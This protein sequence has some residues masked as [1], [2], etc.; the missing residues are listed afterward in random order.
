[1]PTKKLSKAELQEILEAELRRRENV[2]RAKIGVPRSEETRQRIAIGVK[3]Y[4]A[5]KAA[6]AAQAMVEVEAASA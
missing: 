4:R 3:R 2:Q 6:E 1:M 5:M